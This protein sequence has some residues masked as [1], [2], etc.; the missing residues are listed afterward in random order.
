MNSYLKS[1]VSA[2]AL[3]L[4]LAAPAFAADVF[5]QGG[6]LKD[7]GSDP[8]VE[9]SENHSGIYITG[10]LGVAQGNRSVTHTIDRNVD[11][12]VD[13]TGHTAEEVSD[14]QAELATANI[15]SY[16]DG[17]NLV[18]PLIADRLGIGSDHDFSS[19]VFGGEISYLYQI[20]NSRVGVEL[21]IGVT[22]YGDAETESG[23]SGVA[24][25]YVG[26]TLLSDADFGGGPI[27]TGMAT[28]AGDASHFPQSGFVKV[29][30]DLDVDLIARLHYFV[31]RDIAINAGGGLSWA[32]ANIKAGS[33]NDVG[34]YT[35]LDT[36]YNQD[37]TSLGY[38]L[39]AG[40]TWWATDRITVGVAYDYKHHNFNADGSASDSIDFGSGVGL[41]GASHDSVDVEDDVHTIKAKIGF[42]LN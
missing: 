2:A 33:T 25:K 27:C 30:R 7:G 31:T 5:H 32:R 22:S 26:G 10:N 28:C 13:T 39:T 42:K 8:V 36:G 19:T 6:G 11:L 16:V 1:S 9:R 23:H 37:D 14:A 29:D 35:G 38:V 17:A 40:A 4:F 15:P 12:T 41:R 21:G 3:S 34:S 18:V 20:P 24:G